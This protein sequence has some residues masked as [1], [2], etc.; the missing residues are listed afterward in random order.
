MKLTLL[1]SNSTS[2]PLLKRSN[3][4]DSFTIQNSCISKNI[5]NSGFVNNFKSTADINQNSRIFFR[6]SLPQAAAKTTLDKF[7]TNKYFKKF[8]EL[9]EKNSSIAE[10]LGAIFITCLIRPAV[11]LSLPKKDEEKNKKAASHSIASGIFGYIFA[12]IVYSPFAAAMKKIQTSIKDG[13]PEKYLGKTGQ[14]LTKP[15]ITR[16]LNGWEKTV[17]NYDCFNQFIT[18]GPQIFACFALAAII[19]GT[20]PYIDK[21]IV[22]KYFV[23]GRKKSPDDNKS[24]MSDRFKYIPFSRKEDSLKTKAF[25]GFQGGQG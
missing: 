8:C 24:T 10:A 16:K 18:Y 7:V 12:K 6:G 22:E 11:I 23:K 14:Y 3:R 15:K 4:D 19:V 25:R 21:H 5:K 20:M 2:S 9:A 1:N 13:N 17:S